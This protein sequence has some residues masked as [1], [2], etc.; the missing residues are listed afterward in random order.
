MLATEDGSVQ[1]D[2]P[3]GAVAANLT[4]NVTDMGGGYEIATYQGTMSVFQSYSIEPN[5]TQFNA[6]VT[7]TFRWNDANNDGIVD[8]TTLQETKIILIKDGLI[9]TA[10]C[11]VNPN[12]N[13]AANTLT[14]QVTDLSLFELAAPPNTAP[15]IEQI[16][17][18]ISPVQIGQTIT[19]TLT[20]SDPDAG[21]THT[22]IWFW[23]D[24]TTTTLPA[25]PPTASASHTYA[26]PGVYT[27]TATVSDAAGESDTKTYYYV[28]IYD[29]DGGFVT[30]GGWIWSPLGA[31]TPVPTLT[32]KATF[33]FVSKYQKGANVPT[34]T[35]EFQFHVANMNF[36]ST[37]YD[38]LVIAGS[39]AQYKG[40][41][42]ING[43]GEYKF[44]LTAID[45]SPDKF[46]IKIW[47]KV[48]GEVIYDN[49]FDAS[50]TDDPTTAIQ[51]G[52]I[53]IHKP[54]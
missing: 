39:K 52:S 41:G 54:K 15:L 19:A 30:G 36:K 10:S 9:L 1:I 43:A 11:A 53:V 45:G 8:G 51:G 20:F 3:A 48:T 18:P 33:G 44:M 24:G 25:T 50:D 35:T 49:Q 47:D 32:G 23:G 14:L 27:V 28:V 26:S 4:L 42:T 46:R 17:A 5:G 2:V 6:P 13:M 40:T 29:P 38:W 22:V 21:D 31:Y 34:G 37:S 12:C 7:I 16:T